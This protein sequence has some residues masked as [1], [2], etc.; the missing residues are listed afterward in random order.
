MRRPTDSFVTRTLL[1]AAVALTL[2]PAA[3]AQTPGALEAALAQPGAKHVILMIGDGMERTHEVAA[4]RYIFGDDAA[5][6]FQQLPY[7]APGS[8]WSINTYDQYAWWMNEARFNPQSF[9]PMLGY[10]AKLGGA[11]TYPLDVNG[12]PAYFLTPM[13]SY[14]ERDGG[15]GVPSTD[16]AAAG[17]ALAT[18]HKTDD[19]NISW[20]T[21]D[22][23][24]GRLD[25]IAELMRAQ[26]DAA[27]G[28]VSTVPF[29]HATPAAFVS[30]N[31]NRNNYYTG[32]DGYTGLGIA[33]E[34]IQQTRP[35][36]VI[37][38][39]HP[40]WNNPDFDPGTGN[41]S[42]ELLDQLRNGDDWVFVERQAGVNG[43]RQLAEAASRAAAEG[44]PLFGLYGGPGGCFEPPRPAHAPGAPII[45]RET[46]ENPTLA[47]ATQ[48]ALDVLS[49]DDDGFFVMVEQGDIDWANHA[50]DYQWMVG[51][52]WDL[53][54]AVRAV[55]AFVDRP[56]DDIDWSNTLL[57][58]TSDH[59]NSYL[60]FA[61]DKPLGKGELPEQKPN[62]GESMY[63]SASNV[64]PGGEVRYST[65]GH[66]NELVSIYA[67]GDA[68]ELLRRREGAWYPGTRIIDNTQIFDAMAE[69]AGVDARKQ[70]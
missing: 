5:L 14:G 39:G 49:Q 67:K 29:N 35:D 16:S 38:A 61:G 20:R 11:D 2:L 50:N 42:Q 53:H 56:G 26:K 36:V 34:I 63:G 55:T 41:I 58:V 25:T 70:D 18:G 33:D 19:G 37:G 47:Q 21:G 43:G 12:S 48:A 1:F 9:N 7:R 64:Y 27:I 65:T 3:S 10:H 17:T 52:V 4:S 46:F 6:S 69:A 57:I 8:T 68:A 54:E 62:D 23:E 31:V 28:V 60:R 44:K 30:H 32:R 66:T 22:P 13:F 59:A 24:D 40:G 15:T 51:A 45:Q